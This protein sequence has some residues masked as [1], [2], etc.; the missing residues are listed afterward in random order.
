[1]FC[2]TCGNQIN[3]GLNYCSRCG[4]Q[5]QKTENGK[6]FARSLTEALTYLGVFGLLGFIFLVLIMVK[7]GVG[8]TALIAISFF[9]LATFF[10]ICLTMLRYARNAVEK[11]AERPDVPNYAAPPPLSAVETA[12][13]EAYSEPAVSVVEDTT[14]QF[15][16]IPIGEK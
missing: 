1:M 7:T 16:K 13:L 11:P 6:S 4:R 3:V 2:A 12:R 8:E 14:R 10:G 15:E 9:Y 5:I